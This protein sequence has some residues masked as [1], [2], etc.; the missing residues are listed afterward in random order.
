MQ[1]SVLNG[2]ACAAGVHGELSRMQ[3]PEDLENIPVPVYKQDKN[4]S[5]FLLVGEAKN[6]EKK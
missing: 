3:F 2:F 4:A 5:H 1:C 6:R